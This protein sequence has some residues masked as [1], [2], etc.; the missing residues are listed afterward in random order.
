MKGQQNMS[1]GSQNASIV[2]AAVGPRPEAPKC[3]AQRSPAAGEG[4]L[5]VERVTVGRVGLP[6]EPSRS[7]SYCCSGSACLTLLDSEFIKS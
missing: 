3:T 6:P 7:P 1:V 5:T 2:R 4:A